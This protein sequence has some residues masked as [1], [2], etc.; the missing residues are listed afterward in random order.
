MKHLKAQT[1]HLDTQMKY[2]DVHIKRMSKQ[3][4]NKV[5]PSRLGVLKHSAI[6]R[7]NKSC[8]VYAHQATS[9]YLQ[10]TSAQNQSSCSPSRGCPF[11]KNIISPAKTTTQLTTPILSK[12]KNNKSSTISR[13]QQK[14][15]LSYEPLRFELLA[16][17]WLLPPA[18]RS[19]FL[20]AS[21]SRRIRDPLSRIRLIV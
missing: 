11:S 13:T 7:L 8:Y 12:Q 19:A 17:R 3:L 21:S 15:C 2:L 6:L 14:I 9:G 18:S 1:K 20:R 10:M 4:T 16:P 5:S